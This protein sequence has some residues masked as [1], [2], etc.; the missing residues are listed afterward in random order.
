MSVILHLGDCL[1]AATGMA[2]LA[3]KSVDH[4]ICDPPFASEIYQRCKKNP[5]RSN[6]SGRGHRSTDTYSAGLKALTDGAIGTLDD[7]LAGSLIQIARLTKRWA[8]IFVDVESLH[9]V[10]SGLQAAGMRYVRTGAW[11]KTDPM[12][13]FSGDR[14]AHGFEAC[15]I[16][17]AEPERSRWNGGGRPALWNFGVCKTD[18]P[19]HPC[20]KPVALMEALIRDFTDAG[21][22]VLDPFMGSGTTGVAC[23]RLG[24]SFIGWEKDPKYFAIAKRRIESTKEQLDLTARKP[25]KADQKGLFG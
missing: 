14:P 2:S 15:A 23:V 13:Q 6:G 1:D 4:V 22:T 17:H 8:L 24:R 18:R 19:D 21:D 5:G 9:D 16:A 3:D 10:R 25:A 11:T 12:P 7:V 20:P